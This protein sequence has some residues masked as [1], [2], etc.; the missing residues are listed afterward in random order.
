MQPD[1][2]ASH[3]TKLTQS[4]LIQ[5]ANVPGCSGKAPGGWILRNITTPGHTASPSAA[6]HIREHS[7]HRHQSMS[8]WPQGKDMT[9]EEAV[10]FPNFFKF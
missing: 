1:H 2:T 9:L 6:A 4:S 8:P 3:K 10:F 5:T 7:D